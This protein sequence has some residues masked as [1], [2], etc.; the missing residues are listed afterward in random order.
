MQKVSEL[1]NKPVV[2]AETGV[3][4]GK[5]SDVLLDPQARQVIGLVIAGGV[6]SSEQVLPYSD[7]QTLGKDA[8][9]A[10]SGTGVVGRKAWRRQAVSTTRATALNRRRVLTTGGRALGEID[11]LRIDDAGTVEA[12]EVTN[13]KLGGLRHK[14]SIVP[15]TSGVTIGDDAVLV[16]DEAASGS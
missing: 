1:I 12:F 10:R 16:P 6:F 2:S 15:H 9:V 5:V 11:D 7:V 3:R 4:I 14:R 8:V 13:S